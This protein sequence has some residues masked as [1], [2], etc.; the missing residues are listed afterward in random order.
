MKK[1]I[2]CYLLTI[3]LGWLALPTLAQTPQ[4]KSSTVAH[5]KFRNIGPATFSG[6]IIDLA[7]NPGNFSQYYL[8][9]AGGGIWKTNN[10]GTTFQPIFDHQG[11]SSIGCITLDPNNANV[12][13]VG[14]G[15]NNAQRSIAYGDGVYKSTD[16]GKTWKNMGLK[17]SEHIGKIIVDPRNSD[18][19]YVA[20]Q[21]PLWSMGGERGLYKTE[22]GG[23]TWKKILDISDK[24]GVS[25]L[26]IDPTN[27]DVLYATA[28][29]RFR[30]VFSMLSG[31]PESGIH[32][33]TDGGKTWRKVQ[34]GIPG[35]DLGRIA[36]AISP[37]NPEYVYAIVEGMP[38]NRGFYR[39]VNN[40]ESWQKMSGYNTSGNYYQ[41]I[42][43][44][45]TELNTVYSMNTFGMVTYDGG[46]SFKRIGEDLK[47]VDNHAIWINPRNGNHMLMGCD[48]G[49][50][51]TFD[52]A[53]TWLF[54]PNLP[55]TQFYKVSTD[56]D[57]PF[58]N[59]YGGTQDN[60]S[61]AGPSRTNKDMGIAN[62]DWEISTFGD[63]FET[64]VDP[65]NPNIVYAQSQHGF[66]MRYDKKSGE[67]IGIQPVEGKGEPGLRWNWDAPL[68]ISPHA[69]TTLYFAANK[70]FKSTDRGNS[71]KAISPDLTRQL[72]RNKMKMMG[73]VW[74]VDA[75]RKNAS[76]TIYGN[77]VA[78]HESP[79]KAGLLY[80]GTDDGLVQVSE[81]DGANWRKIE[82]V[83][84]VPEL[85]Y[86]NHLLASQHDENVVY[87]VFNNHKRGD[88]KPYVLKSTNKGKSW[89]SIAA[90]LP[91]RGSVYSIAEDHVNS[92][93]L[94]V[95]TEFG[96]FFTIDGGNKWIQLKGGLPTVAIRDMEIQKRENDLVLASFGRGFFILDD[97]SPLRTLNNDL[98]AKD[99]HIF[100][101]KDALWYNVATPLGIRKTGFQGHSFYA[102]PN[103]EFGATFTYYVKKSIKT[104]RQKRKAEEAKAR[105]NKQDIKYPSFEQ[106]R[107]ED[108][109]LRPY[110]VFTITDA[111]ET[112]IRR[113]KT[114][115]NKG[116]KRITWDLRYPAVNPTRLTPYPTLDYYQSPPQGHLVTPGT[117]KV[118]LGKVVDG[119]YTEMVPATSFKVVPL[120]N[121]TIPVQNRAEVTAF[122]NKL[123]KMNRAVMS[124]NR[125][126]REMQRKIRHMRVAVLN[127]PK[128]SMSLLADIRK[129]DKQLRT[130]NRAMNGDGS[131]SRRFFETPTSVSSRIGL[132]GYQLAQSTAPPAKLHQQSL[133][134]AEES[135]A[136]LMKTL[137]EVLNDL[138][139]IE[140]ALE[141]AGAPYTPG[142]AL[143]WNK[144]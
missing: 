109:E 27:P 61:F 66:L 98:L 79:K 116:L 81:D 59:V 105:K 108:D 141:A 68:L 95:G 25:D 74:S 130:W 80:V 35:G 50:Y 142:R 42:Y 84:N 88:F 65:K 137:N 92:K 111:S 24:T 82:K 115:A 17:K 30:T 22:D 51:E 104:L 119:K 67:R 4:L 136:A 128:A 1:Y 31:G 60:A 8:A 101:I 72:D 57:T 41:E 96:V 93:L 113:I 11:S 118:T 9:T 12:V 6:R 43:C 117:Y 53:R 47:H 19:V 21:G 134:V 38:A 83:G 3:L 91:A 54:K 58:Y 86:V 94:F 29:Q 107:A 5:M 62:S 77:I 127:A 46:R 40:G 36:L 99:A 69:N 49:L 143:Q 100:P 114:S 85:T 48:G 97:Y 56:N 124:A 10:A 73:R 2:Y 13:W 34:N 110:F 131:L 76:T 122:H 45:P 123:S 71:W 55:I 103:P 18:V 126:Q 7:V 121:T 120:N 102:A 90:N 144:D 52:R 44:H 78:L 106:M 75:I 112:V 63:G 87:A 39:S 15:E 132:I 37:V 133:K 64:Q 70:L 14:S 23:K 32:K 33:S 140:R 26:V 129:A 28:W 125:L 139:K 89:Q 20:A 16:G 135:F 138:K